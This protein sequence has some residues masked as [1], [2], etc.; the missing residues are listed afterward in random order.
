MSSNLTSGL[1]AAGAAGKWS[2]DI[3][4]TSKGELL[5]FSI[6]AAHPLMT[7][8]FNIQDLTVLS[9]LIGF[10]GGKDGRKSADSC[11]TV[12]TSLGDYLHFVTTEDRLFI[13]ILAYDDLGGTELFEVKFDS[14]EQKYFEAALEDAQ[15]DL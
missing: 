6:V 14:G 9:R 3:H 2:V 8:Q 11:F 1:I 13:R 10:L 4:E 15:N 12:A 5:L 7:L